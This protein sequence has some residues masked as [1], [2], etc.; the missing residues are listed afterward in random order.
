VSTLEYFERI[1]QADFL[2]IFLFHPSIPNYPKARFPGV[3]VFSEIY[4]GEVLEMGLILFLLGQVKLHYSH[5]HISVLY[6]Y[7]G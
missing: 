4:Q 1:R 6:V 7:L 5:C 3:V 2:G